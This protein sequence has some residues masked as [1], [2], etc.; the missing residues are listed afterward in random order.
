MSIGS[1]LKRIR[2]MVGMSQSELARIA[3]ITSVYVCNIE[4]DKH[5]PSAEILA[6]IASALGV[7]IDDFFKDELAYGNEEEKTEDYI[8]RLNDKEVVELYEAMQKNDQ[9]KIFYKRTQ[10]LSPKDL[11]LVLKIVEEMDSEND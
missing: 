8:D 9:L 3:D 7:S 2:S 5:S 6:K 10:T 11:R 4:N 1:N